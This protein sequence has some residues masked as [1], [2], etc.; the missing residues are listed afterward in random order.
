MAKWC[1]WGLILRQRAPSLELLVALESGLNAL[2]P[3]FMDE[4]GR[5]VTVLLLLQLDTLSV[6]SWPEDWTS[7][8]SMS[9]KADKSLS[10]YI[11][12]SNS[13][14]YMLAFSLLLLFAVFDF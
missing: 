9:H 7:D 14:L 8:W 10:M 12:L 13:L 11:I 4:T 3:T 6:L 5:L 1:P 2:L